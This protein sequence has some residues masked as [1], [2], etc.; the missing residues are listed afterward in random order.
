MA[1][2]VEAR[3]PLLDRSVVKLA[4]Q[5]AGTLQLLA[6]WIEE[7]GWRADGFL[8]E[9]YVEYCADDPAAGVTE[10]QQPVTRA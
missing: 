7:N 1:H 8:R 9:L 2:G 3:V 6:R 10:L 5:V 4:M